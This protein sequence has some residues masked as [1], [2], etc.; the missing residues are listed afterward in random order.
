M[1]NLNKTRSRAMKVPRSSRVETRLIASA[2]RGKVCL[3]DVLNFID[4]A[5]RRNLR[6]IENVLV[7]VCAKRFGSPDFLASIPLENAEMFI[8]TSNNR[9]FDRLEQALNDRKKVGREVV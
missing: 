7:A 5:D 9:E 3:N 1:Q 8:L 2:Q 4:G 6:I